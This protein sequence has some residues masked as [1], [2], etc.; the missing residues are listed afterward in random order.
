MKVGLLNT[1]TTLSL[2][3]FSVLL[4]EIGTY[5]IKGLLLFS[6]IIVIILASSFMVLKESFLV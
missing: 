1:V 4:N 2:L 6:G 3:F 5:E